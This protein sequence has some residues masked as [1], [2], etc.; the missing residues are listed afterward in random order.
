MKSL[1]SHKTCNK[2]KLKETAEGAYP[3][4]KQT[5]R[6]LNPWVPL[7]GCSA[8]IENDW[9]KGNIIYFRPNWQGIS[10]LDLM[11]RVIFILPLSMYY[12]LS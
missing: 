6:R 3:R 10:I 4:C 11:I 8:N 1:S 12:K 7:L 9:W 2:S 5:Q